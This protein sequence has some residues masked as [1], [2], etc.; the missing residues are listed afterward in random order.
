MTSPE[1]PFIPRSL[2]GVLSAD[3]EGS[4]TAGGVRWSK[5]PVEG[6]ADEEQNETS[7]DL[8]TGEGEGL[9][10]QCIDK[11][12]NPKRGGKEADDSADEAPNVHS[13]SLHPTASA[14]LLRTDHRLSV[15]AQGTVSADQDGEGRR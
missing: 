8:K 2:R 1:G 14:S 4:V 6:K 11:E 3:R 13:S 15:S 5:R 10:R 12:P 7:R 9:C